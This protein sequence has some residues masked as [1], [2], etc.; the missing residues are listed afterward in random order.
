MY[1]RAVCSNSIEYILLQSNSTGLRFGNATP[2]EFCFFRLFYL[3]SVQKTDFICSDYLLFTLFSFLFLKNTHPFG[4]RSVFACNAAACGRPAAGA[5]LLTRRAATDR[6]YS[7]LC[8]RLS[9]NRFFKPHKHVR[10]E[11][12]RQPQRV[13][14]RRD[15]DRLAAGTLHARRHLRKDVTPGLQSAREA[16]GKAGKRNDGPTHR[17]NREMPFGS[18]LLP[19]G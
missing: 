8:K 7:Y 17:A 14:Q 11:T 10:H 4:V 2:V 15:R 13:H 3:K 16:L 1:I 19:D 9:D 18:A 6:I 12:G 5:F